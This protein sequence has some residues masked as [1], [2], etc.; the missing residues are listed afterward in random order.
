MNAVHDLELKSPRKMVVV[1]GAGASRNVS[2]A[3]SMDIYSPLDSDFFDLLQRVDPLP[4]DHAE[5]GRALERVRKLPYEC[6]R[7]LERAFY[8][9]HLGAVMEEK[10]ARSDLVGIPSRTIVTEFTKALQSVLRQA[11]RSKSCQFHKLLFACLH[12]QD[13]LVSFN[14]DLVAERALADLAADRGILYG[15]WLYGLDVDGPK[16]DLPVLLKLHG[17]SNWTISSARTIEPG[18]TTWEDFF[19]QPGYSAGKADFTEPSRYPIILPF[20]DEDSGARR[21]GFRGER[22]NDSGVKTNRI[23]G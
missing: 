22:E 21:T 3:E 23:P 12:E 4:E 16:Q 9:I 18:M 1:L 11:H 10:L 14:Y 7:S 17:S 13:A 5:V 2:Y 20:W 19:R 8:T 15:H 6:W